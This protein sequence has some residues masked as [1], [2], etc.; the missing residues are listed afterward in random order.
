MHV[1]EQ[2]SHQQTKLTNHHQMTYHSEDSAMK[3]DVGDPRL[4]VFAMRFPDAWFGGFAS[5][6]VLPVMSVELLLGSTSRECLLS[7][8]GFL[9][10]HSPRLPELKAP[11]KDHNC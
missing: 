4:K 11:S 8:T 9:T 7:R 3:P 1:L 2:S 6:Q 5:G 10:G